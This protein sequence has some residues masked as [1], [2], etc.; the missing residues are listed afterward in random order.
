[1]EDPST[2]EEPVQGRHPYWPEGFS[3]EVGIPVKLSLLRFKLGQK[4]KR[5]PQFRF[6]ALYDRVYRSDTLATA[7]ARVRANGGAPGVDGV[8]FEA[9][10]TGEGGLPRFLEQLRRELETKTYRPQP[11]RRVYLRK[12]DGGRRPLGIPTIR[13]R[14]VQTAVLLILEPIFEADFE[15]CSYGFRPGRSAH[16]ALQEIRGHLDAGYQ[17]VY[18]ADLKSYFDSIPHDRLQACLRRRIA[19]RSVLALIRGW[20]ETPVQEEDENGRPKLARPTAGTPQGGVISPLLSNLYLHELDRRWQER[21]GPRTRWN[22]RLVRYADD[23]V[24]LARYIGAPIRRYLRETLEGE[25]GLKLNRD[26][27]R[28]VNLS[29]EGGSLDFL[30]YTFRY[31]RDR[32]GRDRKYL[33]LGPSMKAEQRLREQVYRLTD[34]HEKRPMRELVTRMNRLLV[35]WEQYFRL[36][37]PARTYRRMNWYVGERLARHLR[38]RSQR[39]MRLRDGETLYHAMRRWGIHRLGVPSG[40]N[41]P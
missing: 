29:V 4:A 36:G 20:L 27:T 2:T 3:P 21:D 38:R 39:R 23:F 7:Y 6:Y 17:A 25:L 10:E 28:I 12:A 11:V 32:Y 33:H 30:G 37:H 19:D 5:E 40:V 13:D 31:E 41:S 16:Q 1:M 9:I 15:D 22:A 26:K 35:G 34:C 8:S 24:V 14:V 18:D